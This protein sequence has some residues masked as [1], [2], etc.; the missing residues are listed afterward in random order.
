MSIQIGDI[1]AYD[2]HEL[3]ELLQLQERTVR[4]YIAS[5]KL[6]GRKLGKRWYV[7]QEALREFFNGQEERE[8][9][10]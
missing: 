2:V 5:G 8:A 3:S 4:E 9:E 1:V 10:G 7:S 6:R